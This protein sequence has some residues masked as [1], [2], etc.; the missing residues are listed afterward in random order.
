MA[1]TK[2]QN[3]ILNI[4]MIALAAVIVVA[5]VIVFMLIRGGQGEPSSYIVS[6]KTGYVNI[7]RAGINY[8]LDKGTALQDG[9][10]VETLDGSEVGVKG[11]GDSALFLAD[12]SKMQ[13]RATDSTPSQALMDLVGG[14]MFIDAQSADIPVELAGSGLSWKANDA[15]FVSDVRKNAVTVQVLSGDVTFDDGSIVHMGESR[16]CILKQEEASG[17]SQSA[18]ASSSSATANASKNQTDSTSKLTLGSM[19][20]FALEHALDAIASGRTLVFSEDQIK[21]EQERRETERRQLAEQAAAASKASEAAKS[22]SS[23]SAQDA[24]EE[25]EDAEVQDDNPDETDEDEAVSQDE[26]PEDEYVDEEPADEADEPSDDEEAVEVD[27]TYTCTIQIRC[28]TILN[29]KDNLAE[30]KCKYVPKNGILLR[31]TQVTFTEGESAFDVL[32][33]ACGEYG[34]A[35][36]YSYAPV[37]GSYYVEGIGNLYEFDC[38]DESGWMYKVN[39]WFPNY[40]CSEYPLSDGDA[41]EFCYTCNGLGEDVGA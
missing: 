19:D 37:Y 38:G 39:G 25:P 16:I 15:V 27:E 13:V 34:I 21:G 33:R 17:Q 22:E 26:Y 40:G 36:E 12:A 6:E 2:R 4:A 23:A 31:S 41:I 18:A 24:A 3:K 5:G 11:P 28:D 14:C 10:V 20:A 8:A 9:D 30:G 35:L 32:Q 1:T 7:E 29:N